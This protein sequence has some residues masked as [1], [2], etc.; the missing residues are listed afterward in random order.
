MAANKSPK[1]STEK[2]SVELTDKEKLGVLYSIA[3]K[4]FRSDVTALTDA[5]IAARKK[6]EAESEE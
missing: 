5:A 1:A 2:K 3:D 6:P 4:Y